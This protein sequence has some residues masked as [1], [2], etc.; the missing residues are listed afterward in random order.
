VEQLQLLLAAEA[1]DLLFTHWPIDTHMDHQVA[2]LL[3]LRCYYMLARRPQLYLFEVN[4]GS[5]SMGFVPNTYVDVSGFL[6]KKKS[7]LLAHQSQGG[8]EIWKQHHEP[9]ALFR[10]REAGLKAAEAFFHL[11][12]PTSAVNLPGL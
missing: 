12:R 11:E 9:I 3:T 1:P 4:T 8:E 7:A 10:G 5:Q 2:S 6:E